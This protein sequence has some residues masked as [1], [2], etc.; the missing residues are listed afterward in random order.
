MKTLLHTADGKQFDER[1]AIVFFVARGVINQELVGDVAF[2][3]DCIKYGHQV[4]LGYLVSVADLI[5]TYNELSPLRV[6]YKTSNF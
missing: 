3:R 5:T 6:F 1:Y 4:S 2:I